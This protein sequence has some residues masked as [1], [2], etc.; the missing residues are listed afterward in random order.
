[1]AIEIVSFPIKNGGSFHSYVDV[2]QAGYLS[3]A[4]HHTMDWFK[5]K[6]YRKTPYLMGKS[7]VSCRFSLKP[8][9]WIIHLRSYQSPTA[10]R[11]KLEV[12]LC[13][14]VGGA[15]PAKTDRWWTRHK[16]GQWKGYG[17]FKSCV[18]PILTFTSEMVFWSIDERD[19]HDDSHIKSDGI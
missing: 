19:C 8:I 3:E 9:H 17:S 1:M 16:I 5:G 15:E 4:L 6:I 13:R 7:M 10:H 18:P 12:N 2:Y 14:V 11:H